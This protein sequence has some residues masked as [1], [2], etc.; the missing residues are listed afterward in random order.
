MS[1]IEAAKPI[2]SESHPVSKV[3]AIRPIETP[4]AI[5]EWKRPRQELKLVKL[6]DIDPKGNGFNSRK[7][8]VSKE[9]LEALSG[10]IKSQGLKALIVITPNAIDETERGAKKKSFRVVAG[11]TRLEAMKRNGTQNVICIIEHYE[12]PEQEILAN[13]V[14]NLI[15]TQLS[16]YEI[17]EAFL[18][19]RKM[20]HSNAQIAHWTK[21]SESYVASLT[22][23]AERLIPDLR[24]VFRQR[25]D[26][27][28]VKHLREIAQLPESEQK[29]K[30]DEYIGKAAFPSKG[31]DSPDGDTK[32][33]PL[34]GREK[35]EGVEARMKSKPKIVCFLAD[36]KRASHFSVG[37][38]KIE[39]TPQ[40]IS[41]AVATARWILGELKD[42]PLVLPA[43]K[44][45]KTKRAKA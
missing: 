20:G 11:R 41:A 1:S 25:A 7:V 18:T 21:R 6:D 17:A 4:K 30:F 26:E 27:T 32:L 14:E 39:A 3:R 28:T 2:T 10:S 36:A 22:N 5:V 8:P 33:P 19:L 34:P 44:A 42:C 45:E 23:T 31:A 16:P 43:E 35:P 9:D 37:G 40:V 24:N 29:A 13:I 15:R 12:H 38:K